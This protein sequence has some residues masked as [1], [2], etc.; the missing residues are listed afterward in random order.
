MQVPKLKKKKIPGIQLITEGHSN[1]SKRIGE[2]LQEREC[3]FSIQI[4]TDKIRS[5]LYSYRIGQD[6]FT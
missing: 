1:H 2:V 4:A 5:G 3:V 6:I